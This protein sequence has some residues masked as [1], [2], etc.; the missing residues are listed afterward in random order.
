VLL[1]V[2]SFVNFCLICYLIIVL[3]C[4][5]DL[6]DF[7]YIG[8]AYFCFLFTLLR[9]FVLLCISGSSGFC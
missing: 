2:C 1:V 4:I 7:V 3:A 9:V 8:C 6:Y 5:F